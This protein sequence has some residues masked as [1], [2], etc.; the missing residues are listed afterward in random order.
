MTK[1]LNTARAQMVE[2][3]TFM[4]LHHNAF[5]AGT[6]FYGMGKYTSFHEAVKLFNTR[7]Q[8]QDYGASIA[9]V[10]LSYSKRKHKIICT[11]HQI[12][13]SDEIKRNTDTKPE[14]MEKYLRASGL[15]QVA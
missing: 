8:S 12:A 4:A 7:D 1:L 6:G 15:G 2:L 14:D 13:L 5:F 9:K 10:K 11:D 3:S